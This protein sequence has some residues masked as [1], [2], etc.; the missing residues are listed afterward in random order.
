MS[1]AA[2]AMLHVQPVPAVL[3]VATPVAHA[4]F[5][6]SLDAQVPVAPGM[7]GQVS[8]VRPLQL[9]SSPGTAQLSDA[10]GVMLHGPH[11]PAEHVV[12]PVVH[13]PLAPNASPQLFVVP[14]KQVHPSLA[15][16]LQFPSLPDSQV[17]LA[18]G[19]IMPWHPLHKGMPPSGA[20]HVWVPALHG[21]VH[22]F[23]SRQVVSSGMAGANG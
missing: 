18:A 1:F 3:H 9:E 11:A 12:V 19:P 16:P 8:L 2:E 6:P 15:T 21:A 7:Q 13:F 10:A 23:P 5:A 22:G 17:S 14:L 20:M 4:P